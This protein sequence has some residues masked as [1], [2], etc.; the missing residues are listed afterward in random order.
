MADEI[1]IETD[2]LNYLMAQKQKRIS[3][4]IQENEGLYWVKPKVGDAEHPHEFA[5]VVMPGG[6]TVDLHKNKPKDDLRNQTEVYYH[7][8]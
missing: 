1:D 2:R 4:I 5:D 8:E 7:E 3:E 6:K